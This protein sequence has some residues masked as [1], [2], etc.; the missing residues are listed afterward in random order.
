MARCAQGIGRVAGRATGAARRRQAGPA[1]LLCALLVAGAA[2]CAPA[3]DDPGSALRPGG[4]EEL[5]AFL[6]REVR[7]G[8]VGSAVGLVAIDGEIVFLEAAGEADPGVPMTTDAIARLAS[9]T[10]PIVAAAT[11][12]LVEEGRL[13]LEDPV[14]RYLP[15]FGELRIPD[16]DGRPVL[17]DRP[18]TVHHLL[19]H[20]GGL[21]VRG[22]E[23]EAA[24]AD[25]MAA[26]AIDTREFAA[27][28][29]RIPL[30]SQPGERF[31]Y[32]Y[33]GSSY[34]ILAATLEAASG[35]PLDRL[36]EDR[37]FEPLQMVDTGFHVPPEKR[38]RLAAR[39]RRTDGK[40]EVDARRGEET[41]PTRFLSGG[42]GLRATVGDYARFAECLRNGGTLG[43][44]R[45]LSAES[46]RQMTTDRV[47]DLD[48]FDDETLG[49]GF[50]GSVRRR[51]RTDAPEAAGTYG[52]N[53]GTGTLFWIDP[54]SRLTAVLFVPFRPPP[55]V[56]VYDGFRRAVHAALPRP[57]HGDAQPPGNSVRIARVV[58]GEAPLPRR[59]DCAHATMEGQPME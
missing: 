44:A 32:G 12:I 1:R 33:Y 36:L 39:Y 20:T 42:G 21:A 22:A 10:K 49:W 6:Q 5:R 48:P 13:R 24:W 51:T 15:A 31:D 59:C 29:A 28:I 58:P 9:T 4:A 47:P 11:M 16:V 41:P 52:W 55:P 46:A 26:D 54:E 27:R 38:D 35:E 57:A 45:I 14:S 23:F 30:L 8:I 17:P 43:G 2:G 34:E 3:R 37:I 18:V 56:G 25:A 40:L 7:R 19:T 50:G 53:G